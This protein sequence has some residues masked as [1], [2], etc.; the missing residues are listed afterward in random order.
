MSF[1]N[2]PTYASS[3]SACYAPS[4]LTS[5]PFASVSIADLPPL[6]EPVSILL[7]P[8]PHS[9]SFLIGTLGERDSKAYI[10]GEVMMKGLS[11]AIRELSVTITLNLSTPTTTPQIL[12]RRSQL[13]PPCANTSLT[14]SGSMATLTHVTAPRQSFRI[15]IPS[16]LPQC[17]HHPSI[18]LAYSLSVSLTL[19]HPTS[20]ALEMYQSR[21]STAVSSNSEGLLVI[22]ETMEFHLCPN[23]DHADSDHPAPYLA[24]IPP[25]SFLPS[26][27]L[28][29]FP[30]IRVR[31]TETLRLWIEIPIPLQTE[32]LRTGAVLRNVRA[33]LWRVVTVH[34]GARQP[35]EPTRTPR[36]PSSVATTL[37]SSDSDQSTSSTLLTSTGSSCRFSLTSPIR[38]RLSLHPPLSPSSSYQLTCGHLTLSTRPWSENGWVEIRFWVKVMVGFIGGR[39]DELE[40]EREIQVLGDLVDIEGEE[41]ERTTTEPASS[42]ITENSTSSKQ[43]MW[44]GVTIREGSA[45][46]SSS[47]ATD[48]S[49]PGPPVQQED[50]PPFLVRD[51]HP[52]SDHRYASSS[53]QGTPQPPSSVGQPATY[54]RISSSSLNPPP[55]SELPPLPPPAF[56]PDSPTA[57]APPSFQEY[58]NQTPTGSVP[59]YP[60]PP[61]FQPSPSSTPSVPA[62]HHLASDLVVPSSTIQSPY[63]PSL[64]LSALD[65]IDPANLPATW[66]EY[67]GYEVFS[68]PPPDLS[69]AY[70]STS[71]I[72]PP[73]EGERPSLL[74]AE[75]ESMLNSM[76]AGEE[77]APTMQRGVPASVV[78]E[79]V[80]ALVMSRSSG[81]ANAESNGV[82]IIGREGGGGGTRGT[83]PIRG[84]IRDEE[85]RGERMDDPNDLPPIFGDVETNRI[86]SRE[87]RLETLL[88]NP[89]TGGAHLTTLSVGPHERVEE[90]PALE[91][92]QL[93]QIQTGLAVNSIEGGGV[94]PPYM[95]EGRSIEGG[96]QRVDDPSSNVG[97]GTEQLPSYS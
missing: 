90:A 75:V 48:S 97:A 17:L 31:K 84:I 2:P 81:A 14:P 82:G 91:S 49:Q 47:L 55:F 71:S 13:I 19:Y 20:S 72:D 4:R 69:V 41:A 28:I 15:P 92:V 57:V 44:Q 25:P 37:D 45:G 58:I 60:Q 43:S 9:S 77:V 35:G 67:D 96:V 54:H 50:P 33:E 8:L 74:A 59:S 21:S 51:P 3:T 66:V 12:F 88:G 52:R 79:V 36:G 62:P 70:G 95:G 18:S 40:Y 38:L 32:A 61:R 6:A 83:S 76:A 68:D 78:G 56:Q 93:Q 26:P 23:G 27:I 85:R 34:H 80:D 39:V 87:H 5:H 7:A 73:L 1:P 86:G 29:G 63:V 46:G 11:S 16:D 10:E 94:P 42:S 53:S 64:S 89:L 24:Q 22:T 65:F 30:K